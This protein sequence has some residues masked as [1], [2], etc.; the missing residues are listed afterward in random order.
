M[1][2]ADP[3]AGLSPDYHAGRSGPLYT[4]PT[5]RQRQ[6]AGDWLISNDRLAQG[7]GTGPPV[8]GRSC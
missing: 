6:L 4:D 8:Q 7:V 1:S 3:D 2:S 5:A